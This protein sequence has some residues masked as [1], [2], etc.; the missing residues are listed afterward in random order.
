MCFMRL[1]DASESM[2]FS[3]IWAL[4]AMLGCAADTDVIATNV[5]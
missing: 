3:V 2:V 4:S 5:P 1:S